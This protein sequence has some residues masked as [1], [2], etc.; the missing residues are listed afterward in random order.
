MNY[1]VRNNYNSPSVTA[2][3]DVPTVATASSPQSDQ[4][5]A[6]PECE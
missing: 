6:Q 4:S 2:M 1:V 3:H 5:G